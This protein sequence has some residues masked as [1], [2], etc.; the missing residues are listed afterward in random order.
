MDNICIIAGSGKLP[1]ETIKALDKESIKYTLMIFDDIDYDESIINHTDVVKIKIAKV[2]HIVNEIKFRGIKDL[3]MVGGIK[4]PNLS[5]II[6]DYLGS[7]LLANIAKC[8]IRGDNQIINCIEDF[9][10]EQGI[11]LI[12]IVDI[13]PNIANH[14]NCKSD[15]K[16]Y[17]NYKND[18]QIGIDFLN[19]ISGFDIGQSVVVSDGRILG[20]EDVYGTEG[21]IKR[22][23]SY[24]DKKSKKKPIL[25][26]MPKLGQNMKIDIPTIGY[27]TIDQLKKA[28]FGGLCIPK[29]GLIMLEK[30]KILKDKDIGVVFI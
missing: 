10:S 5:A 29:N 6:P 21:L 8:K 30:E 2:G 12:S 26:K 15:E 19:K 18:I 17:K 24:V 1:V 3:V 16:T 25:I 7:V 27:D 4:T 9:L 28:N 23:E 14:E 13:I 20:M 22:F 11:N